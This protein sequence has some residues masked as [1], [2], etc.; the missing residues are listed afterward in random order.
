MALY[1]LDFFF[2][3][4]SLKLNA[5]L[6]LLPSSFFL[7][8]S[9]EKRKCAVGKTK[10]L[11]ECCLGGRKAKVKLL[12]YAFW[13]LPISRMTF[14]N[15]NSFSSCRHFLFHQTTFFSQ[16]LSQLTHTT[17]YYIPTISTAFMEWTGGKSIK[18]LENN[19]SWHVM[20][21]LDL[22]FLLLPS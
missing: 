1:S 21:W 6:H 18:I 17:T 19:L 10:G 5:L 3:S 4:L 12:P 2:L 22:L 8:I 7:L 13:T 15:V 9:S 11:Y 14:E 16:S 20:A